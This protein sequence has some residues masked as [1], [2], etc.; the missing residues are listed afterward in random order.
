M[1]IQQSPPEDLEKVFC[2]LPQSF[3]RG[4]LKVC[5]STGKFFKLLM[6]DCSFDIR[7]RKESLE[8]KVERN[9]SLAVVTEPQDLPEHEHES[10]V[11]DDAIALKETESKEKPREEKTSFSLVDSF[12]ISLLVCSALVSILELYREKSKN[13]DQVCMVIIGLNSLSVYVTKSFSSFF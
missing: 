8:Y 7:K 13:H 4:D 6:N 5:I 2:R 10:K 1:G 11:E 9:D 3:W 12:V